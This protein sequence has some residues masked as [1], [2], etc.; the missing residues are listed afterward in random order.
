MQAEY[1]RARIAEEKYDWVRHLT[2][3]GCGISNIVRLLHIAKASVQRI[4]IRL[5]KATPQ[6]ALAETGQRYEMDELRTFCA[7]RK[8]ELWIIYAIDRKTKQAVDFVVGR[9]TKENIE[10]VLAS[11]CRLHPA[12]IYTDRL[13]IYQ[14]LVQ[15]YVH[16]IY[17][18]CTN[19]IERMN[20]TLRMSLKRLSRK[21]LCYPKSALMTTCCVRLFFTWFS[22][23]CMI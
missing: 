7:N 17:N 13:N 2:C 12:R 6:P 1:A 8:N 5:A 15:P 3:E 16:H 20:L 4:I 19:H 14:T 21:T 9:R 11:V 23:C 10:K 18:R 22:P